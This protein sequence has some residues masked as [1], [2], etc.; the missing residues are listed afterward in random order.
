MEEKNSQSS[1]EVETANPICS[2]ADNSDYALMIVYPCIT[3]RLV[4]GG[5][6]LTGIHVDR[7]LT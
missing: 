5:S 4:P 6:R 7:F 2:K 1:F 3:K